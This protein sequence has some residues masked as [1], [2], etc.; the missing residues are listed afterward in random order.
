MSGVDVLMTPAFELDVVNKFQVK[1]QFVFANRMQ[2]KLRFEP[3]S[4][5]S[6][7]TTF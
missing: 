4:Y 7:P 1:R 6:S 5:T 3:K 2:P